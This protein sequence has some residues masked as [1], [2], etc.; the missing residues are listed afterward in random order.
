MEKYAAGVGTDPRDRI[1]NVV[2]QGY[3]YDENGDYVK[4]WIPELVRVP[5]KFVHCP[6]KMSLAD[7]RRL[8]TV[9]GKDYYEP[10]IKSKTNWNPGEPRKP[11]KFATN[12]KNSR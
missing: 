6:F 11:N 1:F 8:D 12:A 5:V 10:V 3:D 2:K 7:Q 9:I 4:L